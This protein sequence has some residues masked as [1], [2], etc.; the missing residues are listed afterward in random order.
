MPRLPSSRAKLSDSKIAVFSIAAS[1]GVL[2]V[3]LVL[4][5]LVYDDWLHQTGALHLI[6]TSIAAGLTFIFVLRWLLAFRQKQRE[7]IDRFEKIARMND[8]IRNALQA[9]E[10]ITYAADPSATESVREA[11]GAI[12]EVLKEV[13]FDST[14]FPQLT[15]QP[16]NSSR[17]SRNRSAS[18]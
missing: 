16:V 2:I 10:C 7:T 15:L 3:S 4:Q 1:C 6:G 5:W 12:D 8:R 18:A 14:I 9:I 11:V 17:D 13:I